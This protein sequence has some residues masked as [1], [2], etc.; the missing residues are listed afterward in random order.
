[1]GDSRVSPR[2][3]FK[4]VDIEKHDLK[5]W[6]WHFANSNYSNY[7]QKEVRGVPLLKEVFMRRYVLICLVVFL[8]LYAQSEED[9]IPIVRQR[10]PVEKLETINPYGFPTEVK[11]NPDIQLQTGSAPLLPTLNIEKLKENLHPQT[12]QK[13]TNIQYRKAKDI[14]EVSFSRAEAMA[15]YKAMLQKQIAE[16]E[17]KNMVRRGATDKEI[18]D[19]KM[20]NDE[21]ILRTRLEIMRA[22]G[23]PEEIKEAE[24]AILKFNIYKNLKA[25]E[26]K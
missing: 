6:S 7:N 22:F 3:S 26:E 20:A 19:F 16:E 17:L 10:I 23:K 2:R 12:A 1:M 15:S 4:K 24:E 21:K 14:K 25:K 18:E 11:I 5:D 8:G 13:I 9:I